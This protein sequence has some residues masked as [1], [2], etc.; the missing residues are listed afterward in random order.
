M[1]RLFALI[2]L[3]AA[4][5]FAAA[6][7]PAR[8]DAKK[9]EVKKTEPKKDAPRP[10]EEMP[11][12]EDIDVHKTAERIAENAQKAGDRLKEKDPGADTRKIQDDIIKDIDALIKKAQNPPPPPM[13]SDMSPM[14]PPPPMNDPGGRPPPKNGSGGGPAPKSPMGMGTGNQGSSGGGGKSDRRSRRER[15]GRGSP[16]GMGQD[17]QPM[18]KGGPSDSGPMPGSPEPKELGGKDP[19]GGATGD[20]F[21]RPSPKRQNDKLA[22]LYKDVW[23]QLPDRL[24][25]E[26]DLYYR[27]KFMPRYS[28]L[29]RQYYAALAEQRRK[30]PEDR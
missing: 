1:A 17:N 16:M 10:G 13:Q 6:Q 24:R 26:M 14:T 9:D 19:S 4:F 25:Q 18:A 5:G 20:R 22:D 8:P 29:L 23:G 7:E 28:E 12:G 3:L 15:K 2:A 11:P 30:G 21:G 27:E